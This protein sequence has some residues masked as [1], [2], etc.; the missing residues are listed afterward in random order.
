VFHPNGSGDVERDR[1][2]QG[3]YAVVAGPEVALRDLAP[4]REVAVANR[5]K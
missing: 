3:E 2:L 4:A 1:F 5:V